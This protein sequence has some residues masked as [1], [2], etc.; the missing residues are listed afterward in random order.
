[1][2][3]SASKQWEDGG[4]FQNIEQGI[5]QAQSPQDLK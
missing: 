4:F 2:T 5:F 1:M 3:L